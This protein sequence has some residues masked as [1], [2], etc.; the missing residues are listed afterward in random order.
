MNNKKQNSK[1]ISDLMQN[2][3]SWSAKNSNILEST[4]TSKSIITN[5]ETNQS[6]AEDKEKSDK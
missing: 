5:N 1:M 2:L 3:M 6:E 4:D